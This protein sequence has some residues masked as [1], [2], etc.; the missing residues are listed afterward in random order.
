MR[1]Q[2]DTVIIG[3]GQAGLAMSYHLRNRGREHI[4][5]ERR[6]VAERWHSERWDSLAFQFPNWA[7][8]LPGFAYKGQNPEAF[9]HYREIAAFVEDYARFIDAPMRCG[10]EVISLRQKPDTDKFILETNH[11]VIEVSR[12]VVATGPFQ[13]PPCRRWRRPCRLNYS[14]CTRVII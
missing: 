14:K 12:V 1:E 4:I 5:L 8:Q 2:H 3:G 13:R 7:L 11:S 6:R 9:A 10:A